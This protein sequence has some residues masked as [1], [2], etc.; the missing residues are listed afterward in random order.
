MSPKVHRLYIVL[1]LFNSLDLSFP[2]LVVL[3]MG[4]STS[5]PRSDFIMGDWMV[6]PKGTD[7]NQEDQT[8]HCEGQIPVTTRL[9]TPSSC[10]TCRIVWLRFFL[11]FYWLSLVTI[12]GDRSKRCIINY[13]RSLSIVHNRFREWIIYIYCFDYIARLARKSPNAR[14]TI[15]WLTWIPIRYLSFYDFDGNIESRFP[16]LF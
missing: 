5:V 11:V 16:V 1:S 13:L 3:P 14:S 12:Q 2:S 8:T 9:H 10:F 4:E 6:D 7:T 15:N